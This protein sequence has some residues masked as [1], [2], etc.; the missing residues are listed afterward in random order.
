M[1]EGRSYLDLSRQLTLP[2]SHSHKGQMKGIVQGDAI[3]N[4]MAAEDDATAIAILEP[5]DWIDERAGAA[6]VRVR[7]IEEGAL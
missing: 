5:Q 6:T 2:Q 7:V 4:L 1:P 3:E